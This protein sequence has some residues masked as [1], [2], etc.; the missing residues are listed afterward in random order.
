MHHHCGNSCQ[1]CFNLKPAPQP[2]SKPPL[3]VLPILAAPTSDDTD[4]VKCGLSHKLHHIKV[5]NKTTPRAP[6]RCGQAPKPVLVAFPASSRSRWIPGKHRQP[7][8]AKHDYTKVWRCKISAGKNSYIFQTSS[9]FNYCGKSPTRAP[10]DLF[11]D[12]TRQPE[13]SSSC[14]GGVAVPT[15]LDKDFCVRR[16]PNIVVASRS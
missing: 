16:N 12:E 2:H 4:A 1:T 7:F 10:A 14:Q 6:P 15:S 11:Q 5:D 9:Y 8:L 13:E 3:K